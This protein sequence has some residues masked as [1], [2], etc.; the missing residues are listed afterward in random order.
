MRVARNAAVEDFRAYAVARSA[1]L[2]RAA[3]LL[4]GDRGHAEDLVQTTL[5]KVYV[6]W[7]R[8][9]KAGNADAYVNRVLVNTHLSLLR[10]R[11]L[12]ELLS[13]SLPEPAPVD[14]RYPVE[15]L[16]AVWAALAGLPPRQRAAV[17]LRHYQGFSESET[18]E[19]LNTSVGNV[20]SLTSRG[21]AGLRRCL[22]QSG[23]DAIVASVPTMRGI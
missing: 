5:I 13:D 19:I 21:L 11:R 16:E 3:L 8:V 1:R 2:H 18:A 12:R 14:P 23:E 9:V 20:K 4:T 7:R 22:S 15:E 6:N 10:K 17:V